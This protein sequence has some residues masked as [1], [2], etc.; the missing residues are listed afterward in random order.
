MKTISKAVFATAF[1]FVLDVS[2][3]V[4]QSANVAIIAMA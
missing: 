3:R 2:A 1:T 4:F